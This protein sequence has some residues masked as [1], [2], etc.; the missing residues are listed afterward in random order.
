[1]IRR[2]LLGILSALCLFSCSKEEKNRYSF[3][4]VWE[5]QQVEATYY[6][7]N[8]ADSSFIETDVGTWLLS[9][10]ISGSSNDLHYIFT[11]DAPG[12]FISF[13]VPPGLP[14]DEGH[15]GWYTDN[16]TDLRFTLS[17]P[18]YVGASYIIYT[19]L[20]KK[21]NRFVLQY[22]QADPANPEYLSYKEVMIF[23][24]IK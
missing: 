24:R 3:A 22:V 15:T 17:E 21:K 6:S 18:L 8:K 16:E 20:E 23:K 5:L 14:V 10:N 2:I 12:S 7:G 9:D 19:V 13:A 1:M 11:K 4:G